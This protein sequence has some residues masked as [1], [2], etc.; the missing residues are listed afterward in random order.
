M[1]SVRFDVY[2]IQR[3]MIRFLLER[4]NTWNQPLNEVRKTMTSVKKTSSI[5]ES[6]SIEKIERN[7]WP[8]NDEFVSKLANPH[9]VS[10]IYDLLYA[11]IYDCL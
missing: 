6:L 10:R 4:S 8:A 3:A 9:L 1:I 5:P 11:E 7:A 2:S